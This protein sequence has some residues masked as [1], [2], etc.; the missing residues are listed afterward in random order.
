MVESMRELHHLQKVDEECLPHASCFCRS[1]ALNL[2]L[3]AALYA[4]SR[5]L[6]RTLD[7]NETLRD[8]LRVLHD[9][10][11]LCRGLLSVLDQE[12]GKLAIHTIYSP[13]GVVE[14]DAKYGP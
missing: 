4:V 3:I 5:V 13:D 14:D 6:S 8:V 12:S 10:A 1:H 11:G 7:V 9:E 2:R